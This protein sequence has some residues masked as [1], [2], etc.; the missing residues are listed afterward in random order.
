MFRLT[1]FVLCVFI[2]TSCWSEPDSE[3]VFFKRH[4][5]NGSIID[6]LEYTYI[7][8]TVN[9]TTQFLYRKDSNLI[10]PSFSFHLDTNSKELITFS[11]ASYSLDKLLHDTFIFKSNSN[12]QRAKVGL[13][14]K[15][16]IIWHDSGHGQII[17][18]KI[19]TDKLE[20]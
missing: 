13:S 16:G 19:D 18:Y 2:L 5:R 17:R 12:Q 8:Q 10:D 20:I 11:G 4:Y 7:K 6:T 9:D 14:L 3:R 1:A 15:E